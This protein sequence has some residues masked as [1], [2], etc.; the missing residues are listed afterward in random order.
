M[1]IALKH[2]TESSLERLTFAICQAV[3]AVSFTFASNTRNKI[4]S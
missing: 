2:R 4:C 3:L 1:S